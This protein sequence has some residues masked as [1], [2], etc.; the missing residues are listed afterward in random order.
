MSGGNDEKRVTWFYERDDYKRN[1]YIAKFMGIGETNL[2][3]FNK[4]KARHYGRAFSMLVPLIFHNDRQNH[5]P[6]AQLRVEM[7]GERIANQTRNTI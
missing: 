7:I 1:N 6:A 5:R 2:A 4:E 3:Y